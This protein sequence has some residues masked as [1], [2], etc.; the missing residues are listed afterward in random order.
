MSQEGD[1]P[2]HEGRQVGAGAQDPKDRTW[3]V[4]DLLKW[5]TQHFTDTGI[6]SARLDAE[7]L[8]GHALGFNRLDVY[9]NLEKPVM[10]EERARFRELV[11]E[12][13]QKRVPVSQLLG[14]KEFWSLSIGV[15]SDVLTPRGPI[16]RPW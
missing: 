2:T 10:P 13:G 15:T 3:T 16:P 8:L 11:K 7:L 14:E 6:E 1:A 4:L 9:L 12:R 5:T